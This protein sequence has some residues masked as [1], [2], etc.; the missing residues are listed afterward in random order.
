M[1]DHFLLPPRVSIRPLATEADKFHEV[2]HLDDSL[3]ME[4]PDFLDS[5]DRGRVPRRLQLRQHLQ[6][7]LLD[8]REAL[9]RHS[10]RLLPRGLP[11]LNCGFGG[12]EITGKDRLAD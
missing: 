8:C 6:P 7:V 3:G 4:F 9:E 11:L 5:R 12:V 2:F 10:T 1:P